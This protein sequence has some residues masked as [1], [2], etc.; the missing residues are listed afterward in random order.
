MYTYRPLLRRVDLGKEQH[1]KNPSKTKVNLPQEVHGGAVGRWEMA[2]CFVSNQ[3]PDLKKGKPWPSL[4][5]T[6]RTT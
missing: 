5:L 2:D 6:N 1:P 4:K 3:F